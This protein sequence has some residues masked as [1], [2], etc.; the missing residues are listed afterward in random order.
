MTLGFV[1]Y[2]LFLYAVTLLDKNIS[3]FYMRSLLIPILLLVSLQFNAQ[4]KIN[5][6][7][8]EKLKEINMEMR[9]RGQDAP[10][11]KAIVTMN[12]DWNEDDFSQFDARILLEISDDMLVVSLP[13]DKM[14]AFAQL[15]GVKYVEFGNQYRPMLDLARPASNVSEIQS[16]LFH[17]GE[18]ISFDGTGVVTGLMD[19]GIDPKHINFTDADGNYRVKQVYDFN[20]SQSPRPLLRFTTDDKNETHGTHVAGIMAGS[21]NRSGEYRYISDPDGAFAETGT[22]NMPYYGVATGSDIVMCGGQLYD[23]NIILGVESVI[24][25]AKTQ[26]KPAVVNLSLGSNNGP[27]DGTSSLERALARLGDDGI[28]CVAA[29]NEGDN[30]MFV[31]KKFTDTDNVLK[32]F[33]KDGKSSGIDIWSNSSE[34]LTVKLALYSSGRLNE[35]ASIDD[36]GQTSEVNSSF[37]AVMNGSCEI[38]SEVNPIN[39]RFHVTVYGTFSP[40]AKGTN[41]A[42]IIEGSL[43]QEVYIYGY[44]NSETS[45]TSN[46]IS[47]YTEGTTDGTISGMA[48]GDNVI[49]V[50]SYTT[51]IS[52]PTYAGIYAYSSTAYKVGSVSPFSSYGSTYQGVN[53]PVI[54]APGANIISSL[55]RYYTNAISESERNKSTSAKVDASLVN[56]WGP[57]QGTS[58]ACPYVSGTV[59]LWLQADPSLTVEEIVEIMKNTAIEPTGRLSTLV[60]KQWGGGRLDAL[61]GIQ[62]VLERKADAGIDGVIAGVDGYV[63]NQVGERLYDITVDGAGQLQAS[64]YNLQGVPVVTR[65]IS[66]NNLLLDLQSATPGIYILQVSTPNTPPLSRKITLR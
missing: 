33:I 56:Y 48:C 8:L 60:R 37:N 49:A 59:A 39:D 36:A 46:N 58:M 12:S 15:P 42:L 38:I 18:T 55:N 63:I 44:G 25:Y 31:G 7:G 64:L 30:T 40:K 20:L 52:W 35:V 45:F 2:L 53:L 66:G 5:L 3:I 6:I 26:G 9:S 65:T 62:M 57:M 28:I 29:G 51:R 50:G 23:S 17:D 24:N 54:C 47:G 34:P 21:Y 11:I 16:G 14:E 13:A 10:C 27:H 41:L 32:T 1:F 43:G 22:E 61:A 4:N 19:V